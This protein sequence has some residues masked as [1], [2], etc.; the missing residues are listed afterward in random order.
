MLLGCLAGFLNAI[1]IK[2]SHTA[3]KSGTEA[4]EATFD[5]LVV[6]DDD[7]DDERGIVAAPVAET[8][9][10]DPNEGAGEV[11]AYAEAMSSNWVNDELYE[12]RNCHEAFARWGLLA[13]LAY[14]ELAAHVTKG[15]EPW[16]LSH[17]DGGSRGSGE[18]GGGVGN[19]SRS[20]SEADGYDPIAYPPPRRSADV[21]SIDEPSEERNVSRR[22]SALS[23]SDTGGV[24]S[25]SGG[26]IDERIRRPGAEVLSC[27]R[28]R[29]RGRRRRRGRGGGGERG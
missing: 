24:D 10:I 13:G 3:I 28:L 17:G 25:R 20:T 5:A 21:R 27:R 7:K 23:S 9:E 29:V 11:T 26:D 18:G 4:G 2:G 8:G 22:R 15:R 1:K 19:D 6:V 14:T 12:V 16:N